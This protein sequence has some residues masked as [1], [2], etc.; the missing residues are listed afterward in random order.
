MEGPRTT[1]S[2][3]RARRRGSDCTDAVLD[4]GDVPRSPARAGNR[5]SSTE[6][7]E[8]AMPAVPKRLRTGITFAQR[9]P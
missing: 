2:S 3:G 8:A 5:R 6:F 9:Q 1:F 7:G 4:E